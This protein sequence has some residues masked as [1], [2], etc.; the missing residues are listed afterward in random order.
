LAELMS[1]QAEW[2]LLFIEFWAH[3]V[4]DPALRQEFA[5]ERRSARGLIASLLQEQAAR[6]GV[7]LPAPAEQL[8]VGV[9]A[10]AN[11]IAIEHLADPD[12]VDPS[13]FGVMLGLLLEGL[14]I[15]DTRRPPESDAPAESPTRTRR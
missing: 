1:S 5:R 15:P 13:T 10:L 3:A 8:A 7:E 14:T 11:G 2:H 12:T 4:R 6:A 9:L